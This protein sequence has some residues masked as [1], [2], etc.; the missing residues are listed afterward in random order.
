MLDSSEPREVERAQVPP[1]QLRPDRSDRRHPGVVLSDASVSSEKFVHG[2]K[3]LMAK[4]YLDNLSEESRK[5]L[6]EKAR[7]GI[8]PSWAPVGYRNVVRADGKRVIDVD[9]ELGPIVARAFD[10]YATGAYSVAQVATMAADWGL[11]Y[12]KSR[13]PVPPGKVHAMLRTRLYMGEFEWKGHCYPGIH[14]PLVSRDAWDRVQDILSGRA[15]PRRRRRR[16]ELLF[17]GMVCCG[18]CA[19]EGRR[20]QLVGEVQKERYV[21]YHCEGC[22]RRSRARY[23]RQDILLRAF[24]EVLAGGGPSP[25]ALGAAIHVLNGGEGDC[26][27]QAD[28]NVVL[29]DELRD[30]QVRMD[31]AYDDRLAGRIDSTYFDQRAAGWLARIRV[32]KA[33]LAGRESSSSV[34]LGPPGGSPPGFELSEVL[35]TMRESTDMGVLRSAIREM[36]S[37]S[38]WGENGLRVEWK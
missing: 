21:Y 34:T 14:E 31:L 15:R 12:R 2:I 38:L 13:K 20:F 16:H 6:Q 35:R 28:P 32:L 17:S 36:H 23:V 4:N 24:L 22:R 19:A 18:R 26:G 5:G 37:N 33:E 9:P 11:R 10:A 3:V 25:G 27:E 8:W 29:R 1:H 30:L 7:Q